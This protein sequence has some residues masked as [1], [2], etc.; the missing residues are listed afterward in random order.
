MRAPFSARAPMHLSSLWSQMTGLWSAIV[1]VVALSAALRG[2]NIALGALDG[3]AGTPILAAVVLREAF[4]G[5][6]KI[7]FAQ[8]K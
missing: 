8:A 4:T 3:L 1:Q 7:G 2:Q 5:T 6:K